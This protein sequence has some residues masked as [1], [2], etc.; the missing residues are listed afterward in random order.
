MKK[1]ALNKAIELC[2]DTIMEMA[3]QINEKDKAIEA[4]VK[5]AKVLGDKIQL[6]YEDLHAKDNTI[7]Q[8][9]TTVEKQQKIIEGL[10]AEVKRLELV[11]D[12]RKNV[13]HKTIEDVA[14]VILDSPELS[15]LDKVHVYRAIN[16][17]KG[18]HLGSMRRV[19]EWVCNN[20]KAV[21][22]ACK[23][24]DQR[25]SREIWYREE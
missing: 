17:S 3:G 13:E 1:K 12:S 16:R 4:W 7:N 14:M 11:I 8:Q 2:E 18:I 5:R 20:K 23:L 24:H 15:I 25:E 6:M 10:E 21:T 22:M 9:T 19:T